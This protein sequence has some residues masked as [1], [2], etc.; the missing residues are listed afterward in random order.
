MAKYIETEQEAPRKRPLAKTPEAQEN[1]M[2]SLAMLL[3]EERLEKGTASSQETTHF[4][5]IGST[6]ARIE[7]EILEKQKE[8]IVAKTEA[9]QSQ[10]RTEEL[11]KDAMK[12]FRSYSGQG[13]DDGDDE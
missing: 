11:Y 3:V 8:L 4:L 12:A 5:R 2:V 1:R 13:G 9:I 10:K 7:K 6:T